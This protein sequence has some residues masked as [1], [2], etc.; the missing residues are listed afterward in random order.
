MEFA[1]GFEFPLPTGGI[2]RS[3]NITPDKETGIGN[4]TETDFVNRFKTYADTAYKPKTISAG[5]FNT[6]M[7]WTMYCTMNPEDL[8]AIYAW[9]R[10]VKPV[11]NRVV[12]FTG[13]TGR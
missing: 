13:E 10:T 5:E 8:K 1:G 6:M 2:V 12:K 3:A 7:P 9:L 4:W 11:N